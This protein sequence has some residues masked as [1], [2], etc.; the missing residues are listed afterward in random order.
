MANHND[1]NGETKNLDDLQSFP[2]LT[3]EVGSTSMTHPTAPGTPGAAPLGQVVEGA[4][5]DV[6]S[7]RP[8]SGDSQGFLAALNQ[9]FSLKEREGHVEWQWTPRSYAVQ[10]ELGAVTG[11]QASI[12]SRARAA[13]DQ[14]LPL[15][16]G[17]YPLRSDA[18]EQDTDAVRAIVRSNLNELVDELGVVG[19]PRVQRV[20]EYFASLLGVSPAPSDDVRL[21]QLRDLEEIGGQLGVLR[22]RFGMRREQVNTIEEEQNLTN[23]LILVDH[24]VSLW[25]TW[26]TQRHFFDRHGTDVFLGT[27]LVGLSRSLSVLTESV[28]ESY[29]VMDSVFLGPAERE[30]IQLPLEGDQR[31]PVTIAE[32][33]RWVDR[34]ASEEGPRMIRE[35][36]KDGVIA[37]RSTVTRLFNLVN[38]AWEI[39][40]QPTNNPQRGFHTPRTQ[41]TF[42]ELTRHL[43][44]TLILT[45]QLQRLPAPRIIDVSPNSAPPSSTVRLTID[46][47]H[48]QDGFEVYLRRSI[49]STGPIAGDKLSFISSTQIRVTFTLPDEPD[50]QWNLFVRNPDDQETCLKYAFQITEQQASEPPFIVKAVAE[51]D[52]EEIDELSKEREAR[53]KV[54]VTGVNL[55]KTREMLLIPPGGEQP[56]AEKPYIKDSTLIDALFSLE[57]QIEDRHLR[58]WRVMVL[59]TTGELSNMVPL[60]PAESSQSERMHD[61]K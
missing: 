40:Q 1:N 4:L 6:L 61:V 57:Q 23:F 3:S 31:P 21:G 10:H 47:E 52:T 53:V 34:F 16:E 25:F 45:R 19:G 24:V 59:T 41:R 7:W 28:Q 50:S 49:S 18:D 5:R 46:G 33:L 39:S 54:E 8:R 17:L 37:F 14:S 38:A 26:I 29:F 42:E 56:K 48:F 15:L 13:L 9:A 11:A 2:I 51:R 43:K 20:D 44:E 32:L 60:T 12:Y 55:G 36:G 27:Q 22:E 30:V 35:S 58:R